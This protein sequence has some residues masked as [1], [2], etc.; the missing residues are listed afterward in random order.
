MLNEL[1]EENM[2]IVKVPKPNSF[3][4]YMRKSSKQYQYIWVMDNYTG[5]WFYLPKDIN[6][7][8]TGEKKKKRMPTQIFFF[9]LCDTEWSVENL[10]CE[11]LKNLYV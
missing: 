1:D 7:A 11:P 5:S 10:L 8:Q 9:K 2:T 4:K 3:V 6:S